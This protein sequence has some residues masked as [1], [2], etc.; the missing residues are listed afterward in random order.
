MQNV[1]LGLHLLVCIV[2]VGAVLMQRSEGGALGMGGG[3]SGSLISG[4]GAADLMVKIT[5]GVAVLFFLTSVSLT[6]MAS[7][8]DGPRSVL[9]GE[10]PASSS[11][12]PQFAPVAPA[13]GDPAPSTTGDVAPAPINTPQRAGPAQDE[14]PPA[15]APVGAVRQTP[16][17]PRVAPSASESGVVGAAK[18]GG[19]APSRPAPSAAESPTAAPAA[20]S[21]QPA[22][23]SSSAPRPIGPDQ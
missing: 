6:V 2:L 8:R 14:V 18:G 17:A 4:R 16:P 10:T 21:A 19:A 20:E 9:E 12:A 5:G 22:E 23:L 11:S 13:A 7:M 3:G 1:V 15:K